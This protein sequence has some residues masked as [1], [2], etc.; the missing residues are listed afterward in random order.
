MVHP[1]TNFYNNPLIIFLFIF[2]LSL[3]MHFHVF[4]NDLTGYH[5]WRQT[6][7]QILRFQKR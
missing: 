1:L 4:N 3:L 6:E 2:L 5:V 7:T